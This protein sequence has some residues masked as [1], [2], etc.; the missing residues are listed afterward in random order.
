MSDC[1]IWFNTKYDRSMRVW[2][3][4]HVDVG[5]LIKGNDEFGYIYVAGRE[6]PFRKKVEVTGV[7]RDG[8]VDGAAAVVRVEGCV[9]VDTEGV[10]NSGEGEAV[11]INGR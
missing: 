9:N 2:M 1:S 11:A 5:K 7:V 4:W 3:Q 10:G 8:E 6:G